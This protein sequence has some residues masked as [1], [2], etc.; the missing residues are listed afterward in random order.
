MGDQRA[1]QAI[2]AAARTTLGTLHCA[3]GAHAP[4]RERNLSWAPHSSVARV[5]VKDI[6]SSLTRTLPSCPLS[7]PH[8]LGALRPQLTGLRR[9]VTG[10]SAYRLSPGGRDGQEPAN[11]RAR[12]GSRPGEPKSRPRF[13]VASWRAPAGES[14]PGAGSPFGVTSWSV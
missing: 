8:W 5:L 12:G 11:G 14:G 13:H 6:T 2:P 4:P 10:W 7:D 1:R 9:V 3:R